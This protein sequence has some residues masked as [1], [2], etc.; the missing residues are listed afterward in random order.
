VGDFWVGFGPGSA[1]E[2]ILEK[3]MG[4]AA[5]LG[6]FDAGAGVF[7]RGEDGRGS[8]FKMEG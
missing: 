7:R 3:D 5:R 2:R 8:A 6:V 1:L 4:S